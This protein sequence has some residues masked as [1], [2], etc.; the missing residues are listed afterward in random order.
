MGESPLG[1]GWEQ[2]HGGTWGH[3]LRKENWLAGL[4]LE[5]TAAGTRSQ[6]DNLSINGWKR[7]GTP[8]RQGLQQTPFSPGNVPQ[9][10]LE[11]EPGLLK[12]STLALL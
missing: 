5:T 10:W 3:S 6:A 4:R 1:R 7:R 2:R 9:H 8:G 12:N 11:P